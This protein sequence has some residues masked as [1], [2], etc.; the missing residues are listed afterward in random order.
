VERKWNLTRGWNEREDDIVS[1]CLLSYGFTAKE[2]LLA[3][4]GSYSLSDNSRVQTV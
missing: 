4:S 3:L 2:I 1:G